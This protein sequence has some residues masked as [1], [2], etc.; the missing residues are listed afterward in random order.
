MR[1]IIFL[2][3]VFSFLQGCASGLMQPFGKDP[4]TGGED[5]GQSL[6]LGVSTPA[7]LQRYPSHSHVE[8]GQ[9]LET[10]RGYVDQLACSMNLYNSLRQAGW[11][12]R[13]KQRYGQRAIYIYEKNNDLAALV[14]R[15]QATLTILEIWLGPKLV[16]NAD[17]NFGIP[18][19]S[20]GI[21]SIAPEKF[22][23]VG[24]VETFGPVE[25]DL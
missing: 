8:G 25:K 13:M 16:D 23:P 22:G 6:L 10:M 15:S 11:Q 20:A 9:G 18:Q 5:T 24:E 14:F 21:K 2:A 19:N 3:V 7:G 4:V 1:R 12:L 17:I